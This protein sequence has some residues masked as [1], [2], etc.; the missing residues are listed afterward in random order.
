MTLERFLDSLNVEYLLR[1]F[2]G[3]LAQLAT[4]AGSRV[5]RAGVGV[6]FSPAS[7]PRPAGDP[8]AARVKEPLFL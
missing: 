7:A 6:I 1:A 8:S 2:D 4:A 5:S 3:R